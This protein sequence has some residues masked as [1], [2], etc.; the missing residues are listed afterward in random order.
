MNFLG[1]TLEE[2]VLLTVYLAE[3][4]PR[5]RDESLDWCIQYHHFI[6]ISRLKSIM[7]SFGNSL[8][9]PFSNYASILNSHTR[10]AWPLFIDS[11]L[12][13]FT[14]SQKSQLRSLESPALLNVRARSIF[15]TSSRADLVTFF[16]MHKKSDFS[17]SDVAEIGYSKRNLAEVLEEFCLSGLFDKFLQ[18]NQQRYQLIKYEELGKILDPIPK[19]APSWQMTLEIL[20]PLLDCIR[21]TENNSE[22]TR[23]VEIRNFLISIQK[24]LKRLG[25]SPPPWQTNFQAYWNAFSKWILEIVRKLAHADFP[26]NS[27]LTSWDYS[28]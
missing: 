23:V 25:L 24:K 20:L 7:K 21:K 11:P 3:I 4:D 2:L 16:L 27:F 17:A 13:K 5:L 9:K 26:E 6:S 22:S 28:P 18:R 14:P 15:G 1:Y 10:T 8:N 19:Y 12:L